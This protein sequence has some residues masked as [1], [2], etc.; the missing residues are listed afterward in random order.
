[1]IIHTYIHIFATR[2]QKDW[3][4]D[5]M[6]HVHGSISALHTNGYSACICQINGQPTKEPEST[7]ITFCTVRAHSTAQTNLFLTEWPNFHVHT[8]LFLCTRSKICIT[9]SIK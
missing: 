9:E 5:D 4:L 3:S 6:G 8:L 7:P 1:M 2:E